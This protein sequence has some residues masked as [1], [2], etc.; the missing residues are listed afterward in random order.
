M[1][2]YNATDGP[3]WVNSENWLSDAP[4]RDWYGVDTDA[5]GRIIALNLAGSTEDW[6]DIAPHGL[7]GPI[8]SAIGSLGNLGHL[9]L[10]HNDLTGPIPAELGSLASLT[11][12]HLGDNQL[13]GPIPPAIGSLGNLGHLDLGH[14]DLTGPIPAELGNLASLTSLYLFGN[15][16]TGPI[17]PAFGSLGN[18]GHL[19]LSW[20]D[21]TGSIPVEL[22]NLGSLE[23]L[24]FQ[25]NLWLSGPLPLSLIELTGVEV[26]NAE[27]T[28]LC[29]PLDADFQAWLA[30]ITEASVTNCGAV[31]NP[32]LPGTVFLSPDVITPADPS[33]LDSVRYVGT[34]IRSFWDPFVEDWRDT[35]TYLFS[36]HFGEH[37]IEVQA[38]PRYGSVDAARAVAEVL[39]LPLGRLPYALLAG[40]R[41]LEISP[42]PASIT[43]GGGN[44]CYGTFNLN[45][46]PSDLMTG[47]VE[48][49]V[50]HEAGHVSL[51]DCNWPEPRTIPRHSGSPGWLAAQKADG[52]FI[53]AY[54]RD[55]PT[56]EDVAESI[57]G[58]FVVRCV[59]DRVPPWVVAAVT[60]GIPHRLAYFD[61]LALDTSP[62]SCKINAAATPD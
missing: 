24:F 19:D 13:T 27:E 5:S 23:R 50:L 12:L 2:L 6:P 11:W 26:F 15:D 33:A 14:N 62:Y 40:G 49:V 47:F 22:G 43:H 41:D 17:P 54:A 37:V 29:A 4:L 52:V 59:P 58:W 57:W 31:R 8:P 61:S 10:G 16:L 45:G 9:D 7:K 53:S 55:H 38:H 39:T 35:D 51:D 44:P 20:N 46:S 18:L 30:G 3:N 28:G 56:R 34:G 1:A 42:T 21:L 32:V 48:E 25:K 36:A 60:A